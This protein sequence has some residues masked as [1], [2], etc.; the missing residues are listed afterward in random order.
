MLSRQAAKQLGRL[1]LVARKSV[2]A[3]MRE[4]EIAGP[5]G[6]TGLITVLWVKA[7]ITAILKKG[8]RLMSPFG[9]WWSRPAR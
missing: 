2:I 5:Y 1:P 8:D 9:K 6:E 3:L 7:A 4:M